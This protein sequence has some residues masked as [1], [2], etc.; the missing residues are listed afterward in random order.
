MMRGSVVAVQAI[1][2]RL[3][4]LKV[5][6]ALG[7]F[8]ITHADVL[9]ILGDTFL[10]V[11]GGAVRGGRQPS[12]VAHVAVHLRVLVFQ[13]PWMP[14]VPLLPDGDRR[15]PMSAWGTLRHSVTDLAVLREARGHVIR[16]RRAVVVGEVAVDAV[17]R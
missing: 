3:D 8:E 17:G 14:G 13:I 9:V 6:V 7:A 10:L 5:Q 2:D 1:H 11:T 15:G 16:I 12:V 4:L